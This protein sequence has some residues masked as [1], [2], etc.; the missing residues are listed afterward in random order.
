MARYGKENLGIMQ[1]TAPV[2]VEMVPNASHR[3]QQTLQQSWGRSL[4][5]EDMTPTCQIL[6]FEPPSGLRDEL[7]FILGLTLEG[8]QDTLR[9]Q[10]HHSA[11]PRPSP[12]A[13]GSAA[14][15]L[16][17]G[18]GSEVGTGN[19]AVRSAP[20]LGHGRGRGR[21]CSRYR[22]F[23]SCRPNI[24]SPTRPAQR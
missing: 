2:R 24:T 11:S 4:H 15:G 5:T 7:G 9:H 17:G 8:R 14:T 12:P 1:G 20:H 3:H 10:A 16:R 13:P 23:H 21:D 6:H 18:F 22:H 19:G